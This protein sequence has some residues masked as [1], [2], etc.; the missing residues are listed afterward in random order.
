MRM[1]ESGCCPDMF[2]ARPG[3]G[4]LGDGPSDPV[5]VDNSPPAQEWF[6]NPAVQQPGYV[7]PAPAGFVEAQL[8]PPTLRPSASFAP[9]PIAAPIVNPRPAPAVPSVPPLA[10]GFTPA[11]AASSTFAPVNPNPT[12]GNM[13]YSTA[14]LPVYIDDQGEGGGE[15]IGGNV[16]PSDAPRGGFPWGLLVAAAL[17]IANR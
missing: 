7:G 13:P 17:A 1:I 12:G 11:P 5:Y 14:E 9:A 8:A 6:F 10:P 16:A 15:L 2:D 4:G 3:L